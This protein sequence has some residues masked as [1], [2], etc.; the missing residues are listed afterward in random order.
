M[1]LVID[2]T[3]VHKAVFGKQKY[4]RLTLIGCVGYFEEGLK[5]R[6]AFKFKCD[7]GKYTFQSARDVKNGRVKSCGCLHKEV[8]AKIGKDNA[9]KNCQGFTN[10]LF[11][12]FN[13]GA[14][15]RNIDVNIDQIQFESFLQKRCHY[16]NAK[17]TN[18]F[19][20]KTSCLYYYNGLDRMD[21][22]KDYSMDNIVTCCKHCN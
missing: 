10:L 17:P 6:A 22:K 15:R 1:R 5:K 12:K 18:T 13:Q 16:C 3:Y 2:S 14:K 9:L 4:D 7:C 21:S 8:V 20:A 11:Y 19:K